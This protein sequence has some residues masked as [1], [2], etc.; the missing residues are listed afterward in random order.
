MRNKLAILSVFILFSIFSA[1][2]KNG[3][4]YD[5]SFQQK[6]S[7]Q[8]S[9]NFNLQDYNIADIVKDGV[10]YSNIEFKG[11]VS[12]NKIGWADLPY[13]STSIQ[14][15]SDKNVSIEITDF[16]YEEIDLNS[17]MLPS[18]GVIYRNQDPSSIPYEIDQASYIDEWY[19][20]NLTSTSEP[21]IMREV[22]GENIFV[23]P[24]QYNAVQNK[25]RIYTSIII[26]VTENT[27][28]PTNPIVNP[29]PVTKQMTSVYNSLFVNYNQNPSRWSEEVG[30]FGEILVIYTS[31]DAAAIQSWITWKKEMGF[32]VTEEQVS[33][34]TNVKTTIQNAYNANN[35]ILYVQLVGDWADIKSDL[36]GSASTPTDPMLGCV[37]GSDDYHDVIIGRF[38]ASSTTHVT[39][40]GSKSITYERD[41]EIGGTWYTTALGIGS[42]DGSGAGDDGE[43]DWEQI[44]LIKNDKLLPSTY[45]TVNEAYHFPATSVVSNY[46][47]A[48]LGLINYCGHGGHD[49]W[50]TSGYSTYDVS[51]STNGNKLPFV[52]SV[53]CIVGEFHNGG[54]C[55]AEAM[56]RKS[57]GGAVATWMSTMNQPWQPPMRGQDY[58]NDILIGGYNYSTGG[59][60]G[61]STTYGKTTFGSITYNAAALMVSE[62]STSSDWDTYKTWTIFGDAS[63]QVRT[64]QPKALT[65]TNT[66]INLGTY[67][68]QITVAGSPFEN[69]IVSIYKAGDPQPYSGLTDASGNVTINH[70]LTGTVKLTV[71]G[72]NLATYSADH[73]IITSSNP[74]SCEFSGTPLSIMEGETVTF[75]DLSTEYPTTWSWSF[76]GGTPATSTQ[77][78]PVITYT[79]AGTYAVTL[80]VEN[81]NGNDTETKTAYITVTTNTNAPTPDFT[82]DMTSIIEGASVN[83]TDLSINNPQS[84]SWNFEG[85]TPSTSDIQN[86]TNIV[87]NTAGIYQVTLS[88]TNGNGTNSEIKTAYINVNIPESC[89]AGA[90]NSSVWEYIDGFSCGSINNQSTGL[91]TDGYE[92]YTS[93]STDIFVGDT[94]TATV[95]IGNAYTTDQVYAWVDWNMDS[96]FDDAGENVFNSSTNGQSSY[97]FDFTVPANASNGNIRL[98]VRLND[99]G[100]SISI[101]EPCGISS[102]GEVEDYT[103]VLS[104]L[105]TIENSEINSELF[106]VY[107]NPNNGNFVVSS[108]NSSINT[109]SVIST[110]GK[111]VYNKAVNSNNTT[112]NLNKLEK[113]IY[114]V[115]IQSNNSVQTQKII[116]E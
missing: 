73:V 103:L 69:A 78:S 50:V 97:S 55:L 75:T 74:P 27:D 61:T 80:Y 12:S 30:E 33:T 51:S 36:G 79:T 39:T 102:Y 93:I 115:K 68:T 46:V 71:T 20:S 96:D 35:N 2:A 4:G 11:S 58:A 6:K 113:G 47:N 44:D 65:I 87:Y 43:I 94:Y 19:P 23:Y 34:G 76:T 13:L 52:F 67:T 3:E 9:L 116:I 60:S 29:K 62:S 7:N 114:F 5:V 24:F 41:P 99:T 111:L 21:Y 18:R 49:N 31:R 98:R 57:G 90:T 66:G 85:G 91:S 14:L 72:F 53:A 95:T 54:E 63:L 37:A 45:T 40:Q 106:T 8:F 83:F 28:T 92:D 101:T 86:P 81:S 48:G 59:G 15:P 109:I 70:P 110:T 56:L 64:D 26:T 84:W 10:T 108:V 104:P 88:A 112:V 105:L 100:A 77:A 22:R 42:D 89:E 82:A 107:P 17:P 16:K 32:T 1:T 38:S 25:L